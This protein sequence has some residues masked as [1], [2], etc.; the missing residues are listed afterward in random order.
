MRKL[1]F[2]GV[3]VEDNRQLQYT[4][5]QRSQKVAEVTEGCCGGPTGSA[6][7][8]AMN[9]KSELQSLLQKQKCP[10]LNTH[11]NCTAYHIQLTHLSFTVSC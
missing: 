2:V 6:V 8:H 3:C 9:H 1:F 10:V 11:N 5:S 4:R 7:L